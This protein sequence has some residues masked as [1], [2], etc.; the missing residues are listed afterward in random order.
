MITGNTVIVVTELLVV[1]AFVC[2]YS[3]SFVTAFYCDIN[4]LI[5]KQ[6]CCVKNDL[7][8]NY[9]PTTAAGVGLGGPNISI[10]CSFSDPEGLTSY[11]SADT[12]RVT[13]NDSIYGEEG[14]GPPST[15]G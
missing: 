1:L 4:I 3:L 12:P 6:I 8:G 15:K 11:T 13:T 2:F 9:F 5:G 10:R 7:D 14:L